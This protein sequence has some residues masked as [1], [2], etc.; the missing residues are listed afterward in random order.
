V[1]RQRKFWKV[2]QVVPAG[3]RVPGTHWR[4]SFLERERE[5]LMNGG[6]LILRIIVPVDTRIRPGWENLSVPHFVPSGYALIAARF[7][8][9]E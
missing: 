5:K 3:D 7:Q 2:F 1:F 4:V 9:I 8:C 6:G